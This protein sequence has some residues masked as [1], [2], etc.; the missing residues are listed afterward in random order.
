MPGFPRVDDVTGV[1]EFAGLAPADEPGQEH[2]FHAG[3]YADPHLRHAEPGLVCP[4]PHVAGSREFHAETEAIAVDARDDRHR[5]TA[6]RFAG[7]M[8]QRMLDLGLLRVEVF[9]LGDVGAGDERSVARARD[10][11]CPQR[12]V[13]GERSERGCDRALARHAQRI[14]SGRVIDGEERNRAG[15]AAPLDAH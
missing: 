12:L 9:H 10:H 7:D 14:A 15:I 5:A 4:H 2:G 6:D 1:Y 13:P 8:G 11:H 3:R